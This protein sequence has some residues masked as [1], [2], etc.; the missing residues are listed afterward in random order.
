VVFSR[1]R[2][3]RTPQS[4]PMIQRDEA[5]PTP[6]MVGLRPPESPHP[7]KRATA[8]VC[9]PAGGQQRLR[10]GDPPGSSYFLVRK[11]MYGSVRIRIS[12]CR[13]RRIAEDGS[14]QLPP[15]RGRFARG[16]TM[17]QSWRPRS[18]RRAQFLVTPVRPRPDPAGSRGGRWGASSSARLDDIVE[19]SAM[20]NDDAQCLDPPPFVATRP[21][22]ARRHCRSA[23]VRLRSQSGR[24]E[25]RAGGERAR[26]PVGLLWGIGARSN[27]ERPSRRS[28]QP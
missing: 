23:D 15:V 13:Q 8:T 9:A 12:P 7:F 4:A 17:R 11:Q 22:M 28:N 5:L 10:L 26:S 16:N 6:E 3:A 19:L 2:S 14:R 21:T 18:S 27:Q 20:A 24:S 25:R 1:V